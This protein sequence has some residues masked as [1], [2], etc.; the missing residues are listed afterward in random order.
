[1]RASKFPLNM[2]KR[3]YACMSDLIF[4]LTQKILMQGNL[5][6][7]LKPEWLRMEVS[8]ILSKTSRKYEK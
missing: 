3:L 5:I 7:E 4:E 2:A 8:K 1:M 6:E